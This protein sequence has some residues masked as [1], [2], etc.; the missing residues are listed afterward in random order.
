MAG[1]KGR[2]GRKSLSNE[3]YKLSTIEECWKLVR[4]AINNE[5]LDYEYRVELASRHTVKSIPTEIA[6]NLSHTVTEMPSIQKQYPGEADATPI[7]RIAE[8]DIGLPN[9]PQDT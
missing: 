7:N 8:F 2:S 4:E 1:V 5:T 6:G 9:A 3:E